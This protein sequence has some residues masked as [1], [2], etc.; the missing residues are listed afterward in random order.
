MSNGLDLIEEKCTDDIW[1]VV[2]M[3]VS[4]IVLSVTLIEIHNERII[5][6]VNGDEVFISI[7]L[8]KEQIKKKEI[9]RVYASDT[10]LDIY[11]GKR[12]IRYG[13]NFLVGDF[14]FESFV[15]HYNEN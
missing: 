10:Y 3:F 2:M 1:F 12:R 11:V 9:T 4:Y 5:Y 14:E 13:N 7:K 6:P 15:K 8:H